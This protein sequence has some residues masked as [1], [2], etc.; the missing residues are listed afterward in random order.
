MC[1]CVH[2]KRLKGAERERS[3]ST[4]LYALRLLATGAARRRAAGPAALSTRACNCAT[5]HPAVARRRRKGCCSAVGE[6]PQPTSHVESAPAPRVCRMPAYRDRAAH[7]CERSI[8]RTLCLC[9]CDGRL[10]RPKRK[11][12]SSTSLVSSCSLPYSARLASTC[13]HGCMDVVCVRVRVRAVLGLPGSA[14]ASGVVLPVS[15]RSQGIELRI[16]GSL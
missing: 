10:S 5:R 16:G 7:R 8:P 6:H 15:L 12:F 2:I 3:T 11:Y 9:L 4:H 1:C 14:P 13:M